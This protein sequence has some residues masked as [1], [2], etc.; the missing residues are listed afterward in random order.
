MRENWE[1]PFENYLSRL[2]NE[3]IFVKGCEEIL[4]RYLKDLNLSKSTKYSYLEGTTIPLNLALQ[5]FTKKEIDEAFAKITEFRSRSNSG[6]ILPKCLTPELAY[7]VGALRD[8]SITFSKRR[9]DYAITVAQKE[10]W[11]TLL[12]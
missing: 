10:G 4:K 6:V 5:T 2:R 11:R 9:K 3:D 7:L 1:I 12:A 8:G